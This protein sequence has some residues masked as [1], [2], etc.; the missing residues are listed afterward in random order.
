MI[1]K[2]EA[3][4]KKLETLMADPRRRVGW[5]KGNGDLKPEPFK[6]VW[7]RDGEPEPGAL[8]LTWQ[9]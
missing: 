6:I 8:I 2:L 5:F 7:R 4:V 1:S 3:R 9:R